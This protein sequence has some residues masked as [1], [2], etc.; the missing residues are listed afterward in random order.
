MNIH[1]KEIKN[2]KDEDIVCVRACVCVCVSVCVRACMREFSAKTLSG[3]GKFFFQISHGCIVGSVVEC[4][5]AT[6]AAR[7]RFPDDA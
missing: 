1:R 5:P 7:V 6:R 4:S 3:H 2:D